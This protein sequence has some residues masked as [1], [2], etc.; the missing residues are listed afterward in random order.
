MRQLILWMQ[1]VVGGAGVHQV[2]QHG[3]PLQVHQ[4]HIQNWHGTSKTF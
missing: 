4:E 1:A 2:G 3:G